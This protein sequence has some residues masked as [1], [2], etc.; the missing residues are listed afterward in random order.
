MIGGCMSTHSERPARGWPGWVP[1]GAGPGLPH[2]GAMHLL[3]SGVPLSLIMDLAAPGG[4]RSQE[5]LL[6]EGSPDE[7]WWDRA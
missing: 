6:V 2:P 7:P 3:A 4:P 1:G 5:I